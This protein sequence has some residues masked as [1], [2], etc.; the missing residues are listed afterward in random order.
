MVALAAALQLAAAYAGNEVRLLTGPEES[1][2][3]RIGNDLVWNVAPFADVPLKTVTTTG[4][5]DVL[6]KLRDKAWEGGGLDLALLPADVA[7]TYLLAAE[8]G[9]KDA[10]FWIAPLRV[11]APLY[12]EEI[13]FVVRSDSPYR[14]V[15]DI[16]DARIDVGPFT[17]QTALTVATLYRLLFDAQPPMDKFSHFGPTQALAN[18]LTDRSV[19][20][21]A[22]VADQPVAFLANM[23]PEARRF[24]RLLKWDTGNAVAAALGTYHVST[25]RATS[26]PNLLDEDVA[27]LAVRLYLVARGKGEGEDAGR[28]RRLVETYCRELPRMQSDGNAKWR[29]VV[30]GLPALAP[31]W[32]YSK[33]S[34][35][36]LARCAGLAESDIPDACLPQEYALGICSLD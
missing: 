26:Y 8:R 9:N 12:D 19:D 22:V 23:K 15:Q 34:T 10:V 24:V 5:A 27:A 1:T 14:S 4:P 20:V 16:R 18:L 17:S 33:T 7:Q 36:G 25:L 32:H 29:D 6:Q 2:Q 3:H 13:H 21:V 35:P 30:L 28:L 31:G 11:I